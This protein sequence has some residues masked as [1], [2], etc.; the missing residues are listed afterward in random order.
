[1]R[2]VS[3][4][5]LAVLVAGSMFA[6]MLV[7]AVATADWSPKV[8]LPG[9]GTGT[10]NLDSV[11]AP[12]GVTF[13]YWTRTIGGDD[14]VQAMAID[15]GGTAG[16]VHNLSAPGQDAKSPV[17]VVAQNNGTATVA[18]VRSNGTNDIVQSVSV[19]SAGV[20]GPVADR[21]AAGN[22][23]QNA[24]APSLT[25]APDGSVGLAW[26]R[27][28]GPTWVVQ[29]MTISAAGTAG[30]VRNISDATKNSQAPK[31]AATPANTFRIAWV[32]ED[33]TK[34][35]IDTTVLEANGTP[36]AITELVTEDA[37]GNFAPAAG[38][39]DLGLDADGA[40]LIVWVQLTITTND[41]TGEPQIQVAGV[42]ATVSPAGVVGIPTQF[43]PGKVDISDLHL[44]YNGN[45]RAFA[46]WLA[47]PQAAGPSQTQWANVAVGSVPGVGRVLSPGIPGDLNPS[48]ASGAG[49]YSS[50]GWTQN[51]LIPGVTDVYAS[52]ITSNLAQFP[53]VELTTSLKSGN[54]ASLT[55]DRTGDPT[56]VFYGVDLGDVGAVYLTRFTDPGLSVSPDKV[57][58]GETLLNVSSGV[59][60]AYILSSGTTSL[61]VNSITVTGPDAG[62]FQLTN[63]SP[64][65]AEIAP[66]RSCEV[67]VS[68]APGSAGSKTAQINVNTDAGTKVI[69]LAG[70]GVARTRVSLKLKPKNRAQ[71]RGKTKKVTA[72]LKNYG[73]ITAKGVK[74]CAYGN[75]RV[76]RPKKQCK[77]VGSIGVGKTVSRKFG[78]K[79]N[80]RAKKGK[81]YAV[82]FQLKSGNANSQRSTV[83]LRPKG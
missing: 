62:D 71:A 82:N 39:L 35:N 78:L 67:K 69:Q 41:S 48:F 37:N 32:K 74:I 51:T 25:V 66:S 46:D 50:V 9:T 58:F 49:G 22:A 27:F 72:K 30:A 43:T 11:S 28:N 14:I 54:Q 33:G 34:S 52:R 36:G 7:P 81:K 1:M 61:G 18:W 17:G 73:G 8:A 59:R 3:K 42:G 76:V 31:V 63:A 19:T 26:R 79:L 55:V 68:F 2:R 5:R 24:E 12:N 60:S 47:D 77:T 75:K 65:G 13:A 70:K 44:T 4:L 38:S 83:R 45:S 16:P 57:V 64:C 6:S 40:G 29:A 80:G 56:A 10:S 20:V 53:P 21:S 23:L 15:A